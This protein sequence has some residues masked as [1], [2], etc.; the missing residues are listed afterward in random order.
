MSISPICLDMKGHRYN[1][2]FLPR[3]KEIDQQQSAASPEITF[4]LLIYAFSMQSA[5]PYFFITN[6]FFNIRG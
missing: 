6:E 5:T 1:I 3:G 2:H 4:S